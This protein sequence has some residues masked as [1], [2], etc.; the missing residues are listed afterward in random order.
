MILLEVAV[1]APV[2]QVYSYGID[3]IHLDKIRLVSDFIGRRVLVPFGRRRVTGYIVGVDEAGEPEFKVKNVSDI[4]DQFPLY[5]SDMVGFFKWVADYYHY[6][7]GQVI[8]T[9]LPGGLTA[10]AQ[11]VLCLTESRAS[12]GRSEIPDA[13]TNEAWFITLLHKTQLSEVET[14]RLLSNPKTSRQVK[15]LVS[16]NFLKI[17]NTLHKDRIGTKQEL[18]YRV[19]GNVTHNLLSHCDP[20]ELDKVFAEFAG[21]KLKQSEI[22]TIAILAELSAAHKQSG[23][24]RRE[25]VKLYPYGG[26]VVKQLVAEGLIEEYNRRI[27]RSPFGDLLPHYPKPS[28]LSR[29]QVSV[30]SEINLAIKKGDYAPF[31]L[32]GVTGSGKT[33]VYLEAAAQVLAQGKSVLVLVPEIALATQIEAHFVSRFSDTIA[34]LHSGLTPGERY[35]EWWRVLLGEAKIVIGARSAIFAPL[36][37]PGL[38]IVDEEH[39]TSFKQDDGLRYNGR[40]LALVR[41]KHHNAVVILGSATPSVTSYYHSG[42]GKF[43]LLELTR[44]IGDKDL[45]D[46]KLVDVKHVQQKKKSLF[47]LE[48]QDAL[49]NTYEKKNQSILLLNRRGF[50]TSVICQDC[51]TIVECRHCKVSMNLHKLKE[52]LLC[53]YCG[54]QLPVKTVCTSCGSED[55]YPLGFGTERV[56]QEVAQ[57]LPEARV[58]RLDS[59]IAINRKLF[60]STLQAAENNEIDILI[61]TQIIAKGLHFPNVT[62]VGIVMA[63]SGL[64]FPDFRAA[65]KTYQLIAQVTG[66]AGRGSSKGRVIVQTMQP[67]H[68]AID[69]AA[70]HRYNDLVNHELA[71][72]K[73][74]GFPPFNRLVFVLVEHMEEHLVRALSGKI[75]TAVHTWCRRN[76]PSGSL[77]VLGPAPAPLEKLRDRYRWQILIKGTDLN[78][79]HALTEHLVTNYTNKG[80]ARV[81]I[82]IDP[83]NML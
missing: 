75:V 66:R 63:D 22:K 69:M 54:Y 1:D 39:D 65:E 50:S 62:L 49:K 83:E 13:I 80:E 77:R 6:P 27:F 48:L 9:A 60:L 7:L 82:D 18:C 16:I 23:I 70:G 76:D 46:V 32:H 20:A 38:I 33:E 55:L 64:G 78:I 37:N 56:E 5:Q 74:A 3:E 53:H 71:I 79:L 42:S 10:S 25:L 43:R 17:K 72:R 52:K 68:Y 29:E 58:A 47:H 15:K 36:P 44:R 41:A 26:K 8:K 59:D 45:P 12:E 40:D 61:G 73:E 14:K 67:E 81:I 31:L 28:A 30:L 11:K 19:H 21:R 34:L 4:I 35:D 2:R 57:L 24:P 51:G